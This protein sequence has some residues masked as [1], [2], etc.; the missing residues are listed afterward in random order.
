MS[1]GM[2]IKYWHKNS[3]F[4]MKYSLCLNE[5]RSTSLCCAPTGQRLRAS[6][7]ATGD[8]VR[9]NPA[10]SFA[11]FPLSFVPYMQYAGKQS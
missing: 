11:R 2:N 7:I 4:Q 8:F 9:K 6:K 3:E 1:N 5:M 10:A